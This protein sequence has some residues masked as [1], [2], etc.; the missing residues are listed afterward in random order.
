MF[1]IS[2]SLINFYSQY[3]RNKGKSEIHK[4]YHRED[5]NETCAFVT[6]QFL[7]LQGGDKRNLNRRWREGWGG[8]A[9]FQGGDYFYFHEREGD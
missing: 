2:S 8:G 6:I 5:C 9:L 1:Q 7:T 3:P 4:H